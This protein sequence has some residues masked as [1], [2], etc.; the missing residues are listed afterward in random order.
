MYHIKG[1]LTKITSIFGSCCEVDAELRDWCP[2]KVAFVVAASLGFADLLAIGLD[3][4]SDSLKLSLELSAGQI[5]VF[6]INS[7]CQKRAQ[8]LVLA[9]NIYFD[10][11][12]GASLVVGEPD[13]HLSSHVGK[14][15]CVWGGCAKGTLV[16]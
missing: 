2:R 9:F 11:G 15:F 3:N 4:K 1:P 5:A 12:T 13:A 16:V 14:G 8:A 7:V 10:I 6:G